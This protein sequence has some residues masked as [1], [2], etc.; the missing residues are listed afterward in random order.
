MKRFKL[1]FNISLEQKYNDLNIDKFLPNWIDN[2]ENRKNRQLMIDNNLHLELSKF[3]TYDVSVSEII[4]L[5][6]RYAL[7]KQ[8]FR[9]LAAEV[10]EDKTKLNKQH[11]NG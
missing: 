3:K 2:K 5:G 7:S 6:M 9:R 11:K 4:D 1:P 8:E 10:I